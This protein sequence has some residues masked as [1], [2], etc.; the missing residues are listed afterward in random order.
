MLAR[1]AVPTLLERLLFP[2][3]AVDTAA[4]RQALAGRTMLVT[5]A[6]FGIGEQV[7]R[8][9]GAAGARLLLVAR[10]TSRL[11]AIAGEIAD[12]GGTALALSCDLNDADAVERLARDL[13]DL[14]PDIVVSNAGKSIRR[15][16]L[17]SLDRF[18][19]VTRT[20]NINFLSPTR[21]ALA[22]IPGLIERGGQIVNVSAVNVLL[23]PA[24]N[25]AAYQASKTAFDQWLRSAAPELRARGVAVTSVYLP[26]VRTRMI[27]PTRSYDD[28][29]A[30]QPEQAARHIVAAM[31][32]RRRR[33]APWW[34]PPVQFAS[35]LSR[36]PWEVLAGRRQRREPD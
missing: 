14:A 9:A 31:L 26:L 13:T 2:T 10:T 21:L 27:A 25:W 29:P 33:W 16:L 11:E 4:L 23:Q 3:A 15:P 8:L 6:S 24:P 34:L 12:A 30:M 32:T 20:A 28:V 1:M 18:H 36:A 22:A 5:G 19:D 7:A 17:Q 35:S